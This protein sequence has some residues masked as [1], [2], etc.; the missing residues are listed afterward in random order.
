[1]QR[2]IRR[3]EELLRERGRDEERVAIIREAGEAGAIIEQ[4]LARLKVDAEEVAQGVVVFGFRQSR[5]RDVLDALLL[6]P[7]DRVDALRKEGD[8]LID[9]PRAL[10]SGFFGG[11]SS[12]STCCSIVCHSLNSFTT[13][14][15]DPK[16][17]RSTS[18]FCLSALWQ[19]RQYFLQQR[20]DVSGK[21]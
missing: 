3:V 12:S 11:I 1:L 2:I 6:A 5:Q 19:S 7:I 13:F 9:A 10:G 17:V 15:G 21:G 8:D 4:Q 20:A 14:C 18:P 16:C